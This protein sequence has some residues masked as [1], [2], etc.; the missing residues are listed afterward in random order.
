MEALV[1]NG[2]QPRA[3]LTSITVTGGVP[4]GGT[5]TVS[6]IDNLIA[7]LNV[8]GQ[9]V[10]A[11]SAPVVIASDQSAV[12]VSPAAKASG[13]ATP[14]KATTT[15]STNINVLKSSAGT[16]YALIVINTTATISYLKLYDKSTSP[17]VATDTPVQTYPVPGNVAGAGFVV[18]LQ[19]GIAFVNGIS[20]AMTGNGTDNDTANGAA[21]VYINFLYK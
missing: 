17:V 21:G 12:S 8:N 19:V 9:T 10:M 1:K 4:T 15:A 7:Q 3:N 13:G 6:T 16:L 14:A 20:W 5:G 11:A 2:A 18:P